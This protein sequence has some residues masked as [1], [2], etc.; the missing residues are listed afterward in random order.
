MGLLLKMYLQ[1]STCSNT[2]TAIQSLAVNAVLCVFWRRLNL[3]LYWIASSFV[4]CQTE[5][6]KNKPENCWQC[7]RSDKRPSKVCWECCK[8]KWNS[9]QSV[10]K[11]WQ[12]NIP[13]PKTKLR[14]SPFWMFSRPC[15]SNWSVLFSSC[16]ELMRLLLQLISSISDCTV[17]RED[18]DPT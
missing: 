15:S 4:F 14:Y 8:N 16:M 6:V 7:G 2:S 12:V 11:V 5:D 1:T 3:Y 9:Q 13:S 10:C 17:E 18:K